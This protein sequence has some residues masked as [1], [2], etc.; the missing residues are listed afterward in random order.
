MMT[1]AA[2]AVTGTTDLRIM[3]T[4]IL[5]FESEKVI[6]AFLQKSCIHGA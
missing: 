1:H 4:M 2:A 5:D 3:Y 6:L